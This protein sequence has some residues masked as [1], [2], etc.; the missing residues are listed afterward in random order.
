MGLPA[1]G[2][3]GSDARGISGRLD[4]LADSDRLA[5]MQDLL[6]FTTGLRS[7]PLMRGANVGANG[8][9]NRRTFADA[10]VLDHAVDLRRRTDMHARTRLKINYGSEGWGFESPRARFGFTDFVLRRAGTARF[11]SLLRVCPVGLASCDVPVG[12]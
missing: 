6:W 5:R 12:R 4:P 11:G 9:G 2:W 1:A 3:I 7:C 8:A 10:W